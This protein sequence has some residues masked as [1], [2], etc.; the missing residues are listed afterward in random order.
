MPMSRLRPLIHYALIGTR[1]EQP[2]PDIA[3]APF[4]RLVDELPATLSLERKLLLLAGSEAVYTVA[5]ASTL[6]LGV[7]MAAAPPEKLPSCS[8]QAAALIQSALQQSRREQQVQALELVARHGRRL[9]FDLLPTLFE[10][11][12]N[13]GLSSQTVAALRPVL[14]SL[15]GERGR[16]LARFHPAWHKVLISSLPAT[17]LSEQELS[18]LWQ[19]SSTPERLALLRQLRVYNRPLARQWLAEAWPKERLEQRLALLGTF[20]IGLEKADEVFLEKVRDQRSY[21]ERRLAAALLVRLPSSACHRELLLVAQG[22]LQREERSEDGGVVHA[23]LPAAYSPAWR[24][25][26]IE[27]LG[28]SQENRAMWLQALIS[29]VPPSFWEEQLQL[30]PASIIRLLECDWRSQV[31]AGLIQATLL[32]RATSWARALLSWLDPDQ[33]QPLAEAEELLSCLEQPEAEQFLLHA[34]AS[35]E[36]PWSK[37]WLALLAKLPRPWS[38]AFGCSFIEYLQGRFQQLIQRSTQASSQVE[39]W[40]LVEEWQQWEKGLKIASNALPEACFDF[41]LQVLQP[42]L[43]QKT[44]SYYV[45]NNIIPSFNAFLEEKAFLSNLLKELER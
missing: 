9:P 45:R 25:F 42:T 41:A 21:H 34:L 40:E 38:A 17:E 22:L 1:Q 27:Q 29:L 44:Q 43:P 5:G 20:E 18:L 23:V 12:S 26:G 4:D 35:P 19:E 2:P 13:E 33:R 30:S 15:V 32:H 8:W 14:A 6:P 39:P 31:L 28:S 3:S 16:W 11:L 37:R 24:R 36:Q 10:M 7:T